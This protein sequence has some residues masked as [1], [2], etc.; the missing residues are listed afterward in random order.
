MLVLYGDSVGMEVS[1]A[2]A[3]MAAGGRLSGLGAGQ[4]GGGFV[5]DRQVASGEQV[6]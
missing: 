1:A 5:S 4:V 3:M 6:S 2:G